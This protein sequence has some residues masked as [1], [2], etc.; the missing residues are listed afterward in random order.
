MGEVKNDPAVRQAVLRR[1]LLLEQS[2]GSDA[3]QGLRALAN[4]LIG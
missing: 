3:A 2:P 1:Q 4:K